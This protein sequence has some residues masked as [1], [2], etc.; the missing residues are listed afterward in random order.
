MNTE[1]SETTFR[2]SLCPGHQAQG[3]FRVS[4]AAAELALAGSTA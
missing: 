2:W 1:K 4:R 3:S